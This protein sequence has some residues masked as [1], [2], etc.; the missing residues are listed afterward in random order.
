MCAYF[1]QIEFGIQES[2]FFNRHNCV[3]EIDSEKALVFVFKKCLNHSSAHPPLRARPPLPD[4][5]ASSPPHA[6]L[7]RLPWS[8][9]LTHP[10][11]SARQAGEPA[12]N[13]SDEVDDSGG[14]GG[15]GSQG[16]QGRG[17]GQSKWG[18]QGG[19]DGWSG[20]CWRTMLAD[21]ADGVDMADNAGGQD[22]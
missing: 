12:A 5:L 22:G 17:G 9:C 13:G 3:V 18:S 8:A 20:Q 16:G 21:R 11:S 19:H 14:R 1:S 7:A 4:H 2:I 15:R 10:P 6:R